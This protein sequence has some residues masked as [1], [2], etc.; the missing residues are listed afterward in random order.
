MSN[1][2]VAYVKTPQPATPETLASLEK[3]ASRSVSTRVMLDHIAYLES[4]RPD[5]KPLPHAVAEAFHRNY[6]ALSSE[7]D[8]ET[9]KE[10]AKPW[11]DVPDK[12]KR[13]MIATA[14]AVL[15]EFWAVK[16]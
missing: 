4:E 6:E 7:F 9:R 8:Y 2:H 13:L 15:A 1:Q 11:A 3:A 5:T 16:P 12:N 14:A 10:S